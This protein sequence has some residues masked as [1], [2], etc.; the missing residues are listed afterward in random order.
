MGMTMAEKIIALRCRGGIRPKPG[1]I[2][3]VELDRLMS[4]DGTTHLTIDMYH[5]S[6]K[7]SA[8]HRR[9]QTGLDRGSQRSVR[10]PEDCRFPE[11]NARFCQENTALPFTREK[12]SVIRS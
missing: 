7:A 9:Q 11:K 4:N 12:A 5:T 1:D 2:H 3:T 6:I 10:Q 8:D